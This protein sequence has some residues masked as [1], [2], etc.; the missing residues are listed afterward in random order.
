MYIYICMC[1]CVRKQSYS[2][3]LDLKAVGAA[4]KSF[5]L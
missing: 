3:A 4:F 5:I 2:G 1:V